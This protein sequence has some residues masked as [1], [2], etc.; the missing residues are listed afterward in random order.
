[1]CSIIYCNCPQIAAP[2]FQVGTVE[3]ARTSQHSPVSLARSVL[4][5]HCFICSLI[6]TAQEGGGRRCPLLARQ[7]ACTSDV[8][9]H[10]GVCLEHL[11]S[12]IAPSSSCHCH[13][14]LFLPDHGPHSEVSNTCKLLCTLYI[15]Q[16]LRPLIIPPSLQAAPL[17]VMV[18]QQHRTYQ[19][20]QSNPH[21]AQWASDGALWPQLR[22][23][24]SPQSTQCLIST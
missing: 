14:R 15:I 13:F 24:T 5:C 9:Q 4:P 16:N 3:P 23:Y 7:W 10:L 6:A 18:F 1:M 17:L 19:M 12:Y 21:M 8:I 11:I 22:Q 2:P 20:Y